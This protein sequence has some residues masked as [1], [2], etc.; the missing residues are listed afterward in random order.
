MEACSNN[1]LI[2]VF[3]VIGVIATIA[4]VFFAARYY[5]KKRKKP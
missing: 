5:D 1:G 2:E 4:G 3:A